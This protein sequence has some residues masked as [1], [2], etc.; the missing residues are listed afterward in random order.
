[1]IPC[2]QQAQWGRIILELKDGVKIKLLEV[3]KPQTLFAIE[4]EVGKYLQKW[5]TRA[6]SPVILD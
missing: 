2:T 3:I 1:M 5:Q 4:R 6:D